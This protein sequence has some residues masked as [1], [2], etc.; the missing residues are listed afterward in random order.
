MA[1]TWK[2]GALA[3]LGSLALAGCDPFPSYGPETEAPSPTVSETTEAPETT[4]PWVQPNP[5]IE[6]DPPVALVVG[7][8]SPIELPQLPLKKIRTGG[9]QASIQAFADDVAAGNVEEIVRKCWTRSPE[10]LRTLYGSPTHRGVVLEA[11]SKTGEG[12]QMGMFW[13]GTYIRVLFYWE[14]VNSRYACP[15]ME[16]TPAEAKWRMTRILAIRDGKPV[17]EGDGV[18]YTLICGTN[19]DNCGLLWDPHNAEPQVVEGRKPQISSA[20]AE[21]W[22]RLRA[23]R[24]ADITV[25]LMINGEYR[26]RA[27]D[28]S[29]D[30][31]AYFTGPETNG[32]WGLPYTLGEIM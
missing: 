3:I 16:F 7:P 18:N 8:A 24:D 11:L 15:V 23:L 28:G 26:V 29:T 25:E 30:A 4:K 12:A 1:H 5:Q 14:E 31:L 9:G 10:D 13:E 21:H 19:N 17:R 27:I 20:T 22:D 2:L 6:L 32:T